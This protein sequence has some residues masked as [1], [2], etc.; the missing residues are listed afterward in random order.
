MKFYKVGGA[1][2]DQILDVPAHDNDYVVIGATWEEMQNLGF[3]PV[4]KSFP[5]FLH[6]KTKEEYALARIEK[7]TG[8]KHTDFEFCFKPS[9]TL[10]QDL[11]RRDLTCNAIAFDCDTKEYID[12]FG[13]IQDIKNRLL[14]HI[15]SKHFVEDPLRV[16]RVCRFSAQLD[17]KVHPAT[18]KLCKNMVKCGAIKLLSTERVTEEFFKALQT[19]FPSKFFMLLHKTGAL[20]DILPE[21]ELLFVAKNKHMLQ[22]LDA[23]EKTS[24]LAKFTFLTYSLENRSAQK[25]IS[26]IC[27]R[28]KL[29]K[30]YRQF[31]LIASKYHTFFPD[32]FKLPLC[33]L[34]NMVHALTIAQHSYL[35][36]FIETCL[37]DLMCR[38]YKGFSKEKESFDQKAN[39]LHTIE[40]TLKNI[41]ATDIP[42][43]DEL[44]KDKNFA[45][46]FYMYKLK[47]LKNIF[48][49]KK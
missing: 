11:A 21:F 1:V 8:K 12:Y 16:L 43:F 34:Y 48:M 14:K 26:N 13:G 31:A 4:G 35:D 23:M 10:R 3:L 39:Y 20:N 5:V 18:L 2:R 19:K 40:N 7:K 47:V 44:P 46:I 6:P 28:L 29:P 27:R 22:A 42:N 32:I 45:R 36:V 49:S 37:A 41:K 33:R 30:I 9:V 17:F 24:A 15:D 38:K 25:Q